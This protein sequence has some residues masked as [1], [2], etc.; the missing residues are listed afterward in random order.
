MN[1]VSIKKKRIKILQKNVEE[2]IA[3][4][5]NVREKLNKEMFQEAEILL[6][7]DFNKLEELSH[8]NQKF[9]LNIRVDVKCDFYYNHEYKEFSGYLFAS[10]KEPHGYNISDFFCYRSYK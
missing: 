1:N 3:A 5:D 9:S 8:F 4:L 10:V 2:S 6:R 7:D